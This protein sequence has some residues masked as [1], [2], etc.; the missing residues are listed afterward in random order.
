[1]SV[2]APNE[3]P[4]LVIKGNDVLGNKPKVCLRC[5]GRAAVH[6]RHRVGWYLDG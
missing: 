6:A 2:L 5:T 1:M 3:V 4:N